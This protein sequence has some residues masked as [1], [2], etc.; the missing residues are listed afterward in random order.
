MK[1]FGFS[2]LFFLSFALLETAVLSNIVVL[3]SVPDF[4]LIVSLYLS[5]HNGRL[6]GTCAGF[7]EGLIMDFLSASPFGLNCLVRTIIGY[8]FGFCAKTLNISGVIF[9][10]LLGAAGTLAKAVI[11]WLVSVFYP[12]INIAYN[13]FSTSFAFEIL[14]NAFLTP[15]IFRFMDV[16]SN[17]IVLNPEKVH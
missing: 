12:S 9:P 4:I 7:T 5:I 6:F 11:L 13:I 10:V 8:V 3:P 17:S 1:A 15:V 14:L 16:F 2:C